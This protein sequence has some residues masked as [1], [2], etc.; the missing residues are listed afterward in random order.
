MQHDRLHPNVAQ[1]LLRSEELIRR[2]AAG[3]SVTAAKV[4]TSRTAMKDA[5][6]ALR[7]APRPSPTFRGES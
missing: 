4:E 3:V 2:V 6:T 5:H 1:T 7:A